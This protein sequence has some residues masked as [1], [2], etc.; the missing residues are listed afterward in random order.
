LASWFLD[1]G[2]TLEHVLYFTAFPHWNKERTHRHQIHVRALKVVG[3]KTF[4]GGFKRVT[5]NS[6]TSR[7]A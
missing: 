1:S 7:Q 6:Q 4:L 3:V 2:D 5:R